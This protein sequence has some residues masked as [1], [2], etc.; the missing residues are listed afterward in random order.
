MGVVPPFS[1]NCQQVSH[2]RATQFQGGVVPRRSFAVPGIHGQRLWVSPVVGI[3]P[4][5]VAEVEPT[6]E[7]D[8][9]R[10]VVTTADDKEFLVMGAEQA[11]S[12][13]KQHLSAG[14]VDLTAEELVGSAADRGGHALSV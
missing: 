10:R 14:V 1:E 6:N 9:Q 8:V 7:R 5:A 4:T 11:Y 13:I 12:L 2:H 3:V